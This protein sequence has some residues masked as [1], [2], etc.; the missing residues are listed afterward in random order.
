ME[1]FPWPFRVCCPAGKPDVVR[2][3]MNSGRGV[4]RPGFWAWPW[5]QLT[6]WHSGL[7][8]MCYTVS[9][10]E[11]VSP[12]VIDSSP[13]VSFS[14]AEQLLTLHWICSTS[15]LEMG[16]L[17]MK[18]TSCVPVVTFYNRNLK[19]PPEWAHLQCD[20]GRRKGCFWERCVKGRTHLTYL[21]FYFQM[22]IDHSKYLSNSCWFLR[23]K[24]T[25]AWH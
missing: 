4:R 14:L 13:S 6:I 16:A 21:S 23:G 9:G 1:E 24:D 11:R 3:G 20:V 2:G 22:V 25:K 19:H 7:L 5:S 10:L 17:L 18:G 12:S 15:H 8:F